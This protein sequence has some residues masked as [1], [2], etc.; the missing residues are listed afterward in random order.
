MRSNPV[1][2]V[3]QM[4]LAAV[5]LVLAVLA[6]SAVLGFTP[7]H[8]DAKAPDFTLAAPPAP[9]ASH[10]PE[11]TRLKIIASPPAGHHINTKAPMRLDLSAKDSL[12]PAHAAAKAAAFEVP[13]AQARD[14]TVT[15]FLCDDANR[16]CERHSVHAGWDGKVLKTAA[17]VLAPAPATQASPSAGAAASPSDSAQQVEVPF[18]H[19]Q[20]NHAF[21]MA[22]R[23]GKPVL[24]DFFGIWCPPCNELAE[25]VFSTPEFAAAGSH[26]IKLKMD[27]DA[28]TSYALAS[29]YRVA[30]R[31]FRLAWARLR[32]VVFIL[33]QPIRQSRTS[34]SRRPVL[35]IKAGRL[36]RR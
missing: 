9:L 24:I 4:S 28:P 8:A 21:A 27:V 16:Y 29:R 18:L 6:A 22:K 11:G 35:R 3:V 36:R 26:F 2:D 10:A 13:L 23:Q 7:A 31:F 5:S 30:G 17:P 25:K 34:L 14:F 15:L 33:P 12:K 1:S 32:L 19:N 20:P